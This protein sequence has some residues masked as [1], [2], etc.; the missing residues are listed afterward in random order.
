MFDLR[1]N[2]ARFTLEIASLKG[3]IHVVGL[4]GDEQLSKPFEFT[5]ELASED[6]ELEFEQVI[7]QPEGNG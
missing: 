2:T 1:A 3:R 7:N 4:Q 6:P 5:L